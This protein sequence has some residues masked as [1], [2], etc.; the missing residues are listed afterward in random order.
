MSNQAQTRVKSPLSVRTRRPRTLTKAAIRI[1]FNSS[2]RR[3]HQLI[4]PAIRQKMGLSDAENRYLREY[5][6]AQTRV[7]IEELQ[8]SDEELAEIAALM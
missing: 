8:I 1:Y 5:N 2:R 6:L 3:Y 7:I 4:T